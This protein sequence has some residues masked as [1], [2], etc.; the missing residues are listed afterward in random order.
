M[1]KIILQFLLVIIDQIAVFLT[2]QSILLRPFLGIFL[3]ANQTD[4]PFVAA[5]PPS[6]YNITVS[7]E[8]EALEMNRIPPYI[9]VIYR[10]TDYI[11]ICAA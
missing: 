6:S 11:H 7:R 5:L 10:R 9:A 4:W 2:P 1:Y 8:K 3:L